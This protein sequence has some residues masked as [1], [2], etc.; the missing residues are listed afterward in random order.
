MDMVVNVDEKIGKVVGRIPPAAEA[1][2]R[3]MRLQRTI[4]QLQSYLEGICPTGV[5]RFDN[6]EQAD[7]WLLKW[8]SRRRPRKS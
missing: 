8:M 3:G 2:S 5:F 6:H 1:F 4:N 7:E